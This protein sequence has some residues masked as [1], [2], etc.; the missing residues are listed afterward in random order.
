MGEEFF[1][2]S[3]AV[4]KERARKIGRKFQGDD[5]YNITFQQ[6]KEIIHELVDFLAEDLKMVYPYIPSLE[7]KTLKKNRYG[8]YDPHNNIIGLNSYI[9]NN[10]NGEEI[11]I[12]IAHEMKHAQQVKVVGKIK[13]LQKKKDSIE[14][15][16]CLDYLIVSNDGEGPVKLWIS[17]LE[18]YISPLKNFEQIKNNLLNMMLIIMKKNLKFV[19]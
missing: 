13:N 19:F 12:T 11:A 16:Y 3:V 5:W 6:K 7:I 8:Y 18:D 1:K 4:E 2:K 17:N 10:N 9:L 14:V 15:E